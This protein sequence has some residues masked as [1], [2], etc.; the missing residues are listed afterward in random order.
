M[1]ST[2]GVAVSDRA[3]KSTVVGRL[4]ENPYTDRFRI[5]VDVTDGVVHLGGEVPT[6]VVKRAAAEGAVAVP[7]VAGIDNDLVVTPQAA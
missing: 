3:V 4:R 2:P 5:K 6:G 7:G 1:D